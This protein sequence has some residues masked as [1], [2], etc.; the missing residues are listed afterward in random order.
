MAQ[1]KRKGHIELYWRRNCSNWQTSDY[2]KKPLKPGGLADK[3]QVYNCHTER[4]SV[5]Q[6]Q[7]ILVSF[8]AS[9]C[10]AGNNGRK[11]GRKKVEY[12]LF[13]YCQ[14]NTL[15]NL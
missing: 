8:A 11:I 2:K 13:D 1:R 10:N 9:A 7:L 4:K 15:K 14:L 12:F 6:F 3:K 5:K